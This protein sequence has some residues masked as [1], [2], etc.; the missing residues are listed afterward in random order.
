MTRNEP[1]ARFRAG[2]IVCAL[3]AGED[4]NEAEDR[5]ILRAVVSRR[6]KGRWGYWKFSFSLTAE[7][8][9]HV[10]YV[11]KRAFVRMTDWHIDEEITRAIERA[12]SEPL[13]RN[14]KSPAA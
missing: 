8:I 4:G 1:V 7:D 13:P 14:A 12:A 10:I 2:R 3:F 9:P 5:T 6:Y 11:L